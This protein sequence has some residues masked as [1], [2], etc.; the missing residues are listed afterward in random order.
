MWNASAYEGIGWGIL[1][2]GNIDETDTNIDGL[3]L[4]M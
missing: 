4:Q 2:G 3:C 1:Y